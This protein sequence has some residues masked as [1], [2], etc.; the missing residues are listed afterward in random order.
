MGKKS[1]GG[2]YTSK[3]ER[4]I[5]SRKTLKGVRRDRDPMQKLTDTMYSYYKGRPISKKTLLKM[6]P[7]N[8]AETGL[9]HRLRT[10][11][12]GKRTE[13]DRNIAIKDVT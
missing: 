4:P 2:N 11:V 8:S 7:R 10:A 5:V 6:G 3:G 9:F 12:Q 1:S 13:M